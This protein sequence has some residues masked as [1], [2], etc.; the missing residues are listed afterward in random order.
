MANKLTGKIVDVSATGDLVSDISAGQLEAV[1]RDERVSIQ[2]DG[3]TTIGIFAAGHQEPEM[4]FLAILNEDSRLQISLVGA[5]AA[6][7]LGIKV[8]SDVMVKW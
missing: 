2:C 4:T 5:N 7:F 3:H 6:D 1:P 8:G